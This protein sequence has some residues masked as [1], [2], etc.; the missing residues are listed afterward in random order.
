M[1]RLLNQFVTI[2]SPFLMSVTSVTTKSIKY[3]QM[4]SYRD[5]TKKVVTTVTGY[6][7]YVLKS[8]NLVL[9]SILWCE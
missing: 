2:L 7:K 8:G 5:F 4:L 3:F 1:K 9:D 6:K